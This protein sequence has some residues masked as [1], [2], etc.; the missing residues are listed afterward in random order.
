MTTKFS[1][2]LKNIFNKYNKKIFLNIKGKDYTFGYLDRKSNQIFNLLIENK[3]GPKNKIIIAAKKDIM[4]FA[5]IFACL[6]IG[7]AYSIIDFEMPK[8]RLLKIFERC[9]PN[10]IIVNNKNENLKV[11]GRKKLLLNE[12]L[13][14][15]YKS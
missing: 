6:K 7:C 5:S 11:K 15:K 14:K 8:E 2:S 10:L 9:D 4:T 3:I 13:I 1:A 12:N